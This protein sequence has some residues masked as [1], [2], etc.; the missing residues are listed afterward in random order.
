MHYW[1]N[2]FQNDAYNLL[3]LNEIHQVFYGDDFK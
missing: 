1:A 3:N 2:V